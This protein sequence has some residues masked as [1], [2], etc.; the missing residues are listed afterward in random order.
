MILFTAEHGNKKMGKKHAR[1]GIGRCWVEMRPKPLSGE[2]WI[3][4]N[5]AYLDWVRKKEFNDTAYWKRLWRAYAVGRPILRRGARYRRSGHEEP[6]IFD[7]VDRTTA[8]IVVMVSC[9]SR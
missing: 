3:F 9:D 1:E 6:G 7:V 8:P 4:D 5:G 2:P